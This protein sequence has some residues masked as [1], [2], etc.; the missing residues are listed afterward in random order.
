[1]TDVE[2]IK[3]KIDIVAFLSDYIQV[4][5]AGRNFKALC[6]F[7]GEKTPSFVISPERN[8]W[9][10]FGA[11]AEGGDAIKF[12]QKWENIDFLEAL[13]ILA[14]KTGVTLSHYTPSEEGRKK[15]ILYEVNH[16]A[17][18]FYHYLLT[19]HPMGKKAI[20]YLKNRAIKD[21]TIKTFGL[22]YAPDSWESLLRFLSKK[23]Y[24]N[25]DIYT[26]GLVVKSER[27]KF[28][29][30]F[31]G[32]LMFTLKDHRGNIIGFSGRLLNENDPEKERGAKYVNTSETPIYS[33]G[34]TLYGLD[35]T[36]D[37][38][39]REKEAI[40]VEGE[41][42]LLSS[43]QMGIT[44][45][46][47]IKGSA[48][49]EGQTLLLKRFS[50]QVI[51]AL[52]SDF[53]GNEAAKRGIEIAENANLSV[54]V[55]KLTEGKDPAEAISI[56]PSLWRKALQSAIP[57]YD[58][59][60]EN[61]IEKYNGKGVLGIKEIS[62]EVIPFLAK[63]ENPIIFS[64]YLKYLAKKLDVSEESVEIAIRQFQKKQTA[65]TNVAVATLTKPLRDTLL[66][67]YLIALIIQSQNPLES[68]KK[69]KDSLS[70][71]DFHEPTVANIFGLLTSYFKSHE[72][73]DI[74]NFGKILTPEVTPTFD[75]ALLLDIENTLKVNK[76]YDKELRETVKEVKKISLRRRINILSTKIRQ[77]ENDTE[78]NNV[79]TLQQE[80]RQLIEDLRDVDN[81]ASKG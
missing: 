27:G 22:G 37:S 23:G 74:Q 68:F 20:G 6:P 5:K 44:N 21:E 58:F 77:E 25:E 14:K 13:K 16:L 63:I 69:A 18:E 34:N 31:R 26:A 3:S 42:D 17:S 30:R 33:K 7:H 9:H 78:D 57:I 72:K 12:L 45:I 52:D 76:K 62:T 66:E 75:K 51:L 55:T 35:I 28:Y 81:S 71:S 32:R 46:V 43:F 53:A 65:K 60:I 73:L 67:E 70:V 40:V 1:M 2:L 80:V 47:A 61:A 19:S 4:K 8:S 11:C 59:I 48:L 64:H 41:F 39:K 79:K 29:D 50:D 24:Q 10:C 49:T 54:K 15:E 56:N 38:I 36:R